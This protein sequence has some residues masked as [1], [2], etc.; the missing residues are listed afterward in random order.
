MRRGR[1]I[2]I[3]LVTLTIR[4][5]AQSIFTIA[6][7]GTEDGR[8]ATAVGLTSPFGLALDAAGNLYVADY[9][10]N[11]ILEIAAG[12][13]I[14]SSIAGNGSRGF[15]GDHGPATAATLDGPTDMVF[16]ANANLYIADNGNRRIREVVRETGIILTIAG[17]GGTAFSGD[18]GPATAASL[19]PAGLAFDAA[20][21]LYILDGGNQRVRRIA[22][23]TGV[24]TTVAG[25]GPGGFTPGSFSGDG[26][27]AT[28]AAL[29]VTISG[30]ALD[31][32]GNLFI[33]DFFNNRI[34]KVSAGSGLI[35]TVAGSGSAG[36]NGSFSGDGGQATAA[37][38]NRPTNVAVDHAGNL[39]IADEHNARIR[40]V[41]YATGLI[42]TIAGGGTSPGDALPATST[43]LMLPYDIAIDAA[44]NLYI[45]DTFDNR[46]RKVSANG[47]ITTVAGNETQGFLGDGGP[48]TAAHLFLPFDL[49][50]DAAGNLSIAD[51]D[52]RRIRSVS[53]DKQIISTV[54]GRGPAFPFGTGFSGD[55]GQASAAMLGALGVAFDLAGN[56]YAADTVNNRIR[57]VD[58][59]TGVINTIAGGGAAANGPFSGDG[60]PASAATL[61]QPHRL[62]ID[63]AGNLYF[64]DTYNNRIRRV[65]F[66]SGIITTMAGSGS[67]A[68]AP[69]VA[70]PGAYSGDGGPATAAML[71]GPQ[72]VAIDRRGNLFIADTSNNR[73]RR[74]S[75]GNGIISTVAGGGSAGDGGP[76]TAA[77][78][79]APQGVAVDVNGNLFIT[80]SFHR[81]RKVDA[82]SGVITTVAGNGSSEFSGDGGRATAAGL[83]GPT[84]IAV[85]AAGDLLIADAGANRVRIVPACA[86][87]SSPALQ[88]PADGSASVSLDPRLAWSAVTSALHYDIYLGRTNPP[89]TMVASDVVTPQYGLSNLDPLTTYY[90][91]VVAKGDPL[92]VPPSSSAS[93]VFAFVTRG[94]CSPPGAFVGE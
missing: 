58:R 12:N 26:G 4:V 22:A 7:G 63:T 73:V 61:N 88:Q 90:W 80:D 5:S 28:A 59:E 91:R 21:N 70:A 33:A 29:N 16:D 25:S 44:S 65:E 1:Y 8:P 36:G 37:T 82:V 68:N 79:A 48:A 84:A 40:R 93:P 81:I 15:S 86:P 66:G 20:G 32:A 77:A 76:A 31:A 55:G 2:V 72:G 9:Y 83:A 30:I 52:N 17:N 89:Q 34:R 3:F 92:C 14:I 53:A 47:V 19:S 10:D 60:G 13:G 6:G 56:L 49:A 87:V 27:P 69:G 45:A 85:N 18:G 24:I 46:I 41:D 57:R 11:R 75:L 39:Y 64:S 71:N 62:V 54:A 67:V 43:S 78:I 50:L 74:V 51:F 38:L 42:T 94:G 35:S 23:G